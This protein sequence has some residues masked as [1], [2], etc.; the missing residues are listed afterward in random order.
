VCGVWLTEIFPSKLQKSIILR[1]NCRDHIRK[2]TKIT[3]E[4][5]HTDKIGTH[6]GG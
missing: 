2:D 3:A 4:R 6:M 5:K 1:A